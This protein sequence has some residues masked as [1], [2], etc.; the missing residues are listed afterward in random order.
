MPLP[1]WAKW[2]RLAVAEISPAIIRKSVIA[3]KSLKRRKK[4]DGAG[5]M[6]ADEDLFAGFFAPLRFF[7]A[8]LFPAA[9]PRGNIHR[10]SQ[11]PATGRS[12]DRHTFALS[13]LA[14]YNASTG[15]TLGCGPSS[16]AWSYSPQIFSARTRRTPTPRETCTSPSASPRTIPKAPP[17]TRKQQNSTDF[18]VISRNVGGV[19]QPTRLGEGSRISGKLSL[20]FV[21]HGEPAH[22]LPGPATA[23]ITR[24]SNSASAVIARFWHKHN[25][26]ANKLLCRPLLPWTDYIGLHCALGRSINRWRSGLDS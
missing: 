10:S 9:A 13:T 4:G 24:S 21:T 17:N 26:D 14:H 23:R 20:A 15:P 1:H 16:N 11:P 18:H 8:I 5:G 25:E 3:A 7:V 6:H 19:N 12:G 22:G 2:P